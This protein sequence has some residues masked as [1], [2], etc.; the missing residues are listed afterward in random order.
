MGKG[1]IGIG[2]SSYG[3]NS[4]KLALLTTTFTL[5]YGGRYELY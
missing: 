4:T 2:S 5:L 3:E 1:N